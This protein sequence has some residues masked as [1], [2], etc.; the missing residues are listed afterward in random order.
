[1]RYLPIAVL[2]AG[3][4]LPATAQA[5]SIS[6]IKDGDVWIAAPDGSNQTRITTLGTYKAASQG[7]DGTLVA[8]S[9]SRIHRID[10]TTGAV[11]NQIN[12]PLGPGWFGPWEPAVSPDG[13]KVAYEIRDF[14]GYPAVAYS[15]TDG[16]I[17][18]RPLH[19]GWTWP[20]WIDNEW[21]VHSEKPNALSKDTI[22]RK[23]GSPNNEGTAW[24]THPGR[25]PLADVDIKGNLFAGITDDALLTVFRFTG[26]PGTGEV[27]GC[28][29][30]EDPSGGKFTGPSFSPDARS[31]L[32]GEGDGIWRGDMPDLSGACVA[33]PNGR[34]II[35]GAYNPDWS[36]AGVPTIAPPPPPPGTPP[37]P[38]PPVVVDP[39]VKP[40]AISASK[41]RLKTVLKKGLTVKLAN[42]TGKTKVTATYKKKI[43]ASGS[44]TTTVKLTFTRKAAR[45][46]KRKKRVSLTLKAGAVT[47]TITLK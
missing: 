7:E 1:M 24:F 26:D 16:S 21:L 41:Q 15:N 35:P 27:E 39:G 12:T 14:N 19:T 10:R 8:V 3:L 22:V 6:Y 44:G 4:A 20:S 28:F 13:T 33:P 2:L 47:Q 45:D 31:L 38:P 29:Q 40:I 46:L 18:S 43:V 36:G 5:D 37:P 25:T 11:L 9:G 23:V 32:W 30:Y 17:V 42:A 34:L